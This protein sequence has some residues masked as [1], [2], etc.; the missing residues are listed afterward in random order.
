MRETN[1]RSVLGQNNNVGILEK[2]KTSML[3]SL[4]CVEQIVK[5]ME[6]KKKADTILFV[7]PEHWL[8]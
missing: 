8:D 7:Y 4:V 3:Y 2:A 6:K 5:K 1:G